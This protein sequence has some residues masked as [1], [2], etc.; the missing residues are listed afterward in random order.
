MKPVTQTSF[1]SV[2]GNCFRACLA[3]LLEIPLTSIP[4]SVVSHGNLAARRAFLAKYGLALVF[5]R[6]KV[7]ADWGWIPPT[8][9]HLISGP[10]PRG[11]EKTH[12]C[13]GY[14]GKLVFDPHP[15]RLGL[16]GT[17][18]RIGLFI[19]LNPVD[20]LPPMPQ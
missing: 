15:S 18:R 17:E 8:A 2:G 20:V 1:T 9:Y 3:S 12:A 10:S 4:D 19:V 13:V 11:H 5:R 6:T 14:G 16:A 7:G